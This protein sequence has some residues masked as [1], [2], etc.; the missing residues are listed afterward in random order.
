[1]LDRD[2][3][4]QRQGSPEVAVRLEGVTKSYGPRP[5]LRGLTLEV[6]RGSIFALLGPNGA[7]KTTTLRLLLGL[8]RPDGG[9]GEVLGFKLGAGP[10]VHPGRTGRSGH[11]AY[12]PVALKQRLG[13]VP[14]RNSLYERQTAGELL[15]LC[16]SLNPRWDDTTIRRYLDLFRFPLDVEVKHLS[17]GT[18]AQLALTLAMGGNPD[19]LILDEPT[20]GLDPAHRHQYYQVLLE[21]SMETGRT[22]LL[23]S[24]DLHQV[25]RL[26]D[27]VAIMKEGTLAVCGA[28]DALKEREKRLRVSGRPD[29]PALAAVPGVRLVVPEG[30]GPVFLL[31]ARGDPDELR[32][33]LL[34][35]P[36]V[37]GVQVYD[38][39]L[40]E[41]FLSYCG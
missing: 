12:P 39:S 31:H 29:V 7:G 16:R 20:Q 35:V 15:G 5:A 14:E 6:G 34:A 37:H 24:H 1:M 8:V 26:A 4:A 2:C 10:S 32:E 19:L 30:P 25:E 41:I 28:L 13:Y 3:A 17:A 11:P 27:H 36:G 22:I 23:S 18:R 38:Q 9:S 33:R 21:D 40:E